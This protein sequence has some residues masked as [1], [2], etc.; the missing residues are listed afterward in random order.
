MVL[1]YLR[2]VSRV[3][4]RRLESFYGPGLNNLLLCVAVGAQGSHSARTTF[5][6]VLPFLMVLVVP[7]V[8]ASSSE[9]L[10]QV[11]RT[12]SALFPLTGWERGLG[13]AAGVLLNPLVWVIAG[14]LLAWSGAAA[15]GGFLLLALA[16][17]LAVA[18]A[19]AV[20]ARL[21]HD[22][23][24]RGR[25]RFRGDP[26][27]LVR[28]REVFATLDLWAAVLIAGAGVAYRVLTPAPDPAARG[29]LGV[30]IALTL[31]TLAQRSFS[32]TGPGGVTRYRLLG[33]RGWRILLAYDVALL[34]VTGLLSAPFHL[35]AGLGCMLV[36]LAVG[37]WPAVRQEAWGR[38]WRL[39]AGDI[40]FGAAQ[41]VFGVMA[42]AGTVALGARVL[43]AACLVYAV[44]L[45]AGDRWWSR[46]W[47]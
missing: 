35:G 16:V 15:C 39:S 8:A 23:W 24:Q 36:A 17:Q 2:L 27:V 45:W 7:M 12:R 14:I 3:S 43:I 38:R 10:E 22:L 20:A 41:V 19:G 18:G 34:L 47:K 46:R 4:R 13:P 30:L 29:V 21:P 1:A 44:S 11:P 32:L 25:L 33:L 26:L 6:S 28:L 40:R 9:A 42:G 31:S 5:W 37:R